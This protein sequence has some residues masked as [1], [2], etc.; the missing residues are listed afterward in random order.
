MI[1]SK[2][3]FRISLFGGGTDFPK[4]YEKYNGKVIGF[5]F[6]R[7]N[8]ILFRSKF[9][10]NNNKF[11]INYSK[12]EKVNNI[13]NIKHPSVRE[14]LKYLKFKDPFELHYNGELPARSGLG[15]S[16]AFTVGLLKILQTIKKKN[17]SALEI[18]KKAIDIEQNKIK[19]IVGSQDQFYASLGGFKKISF[20]KENIRCKNVNIS[21]LNKKKLEDSM[22]LV[23]TGRVR[24]AEKIE[25]QKLQ[26]FEK[27]LKALDELKDYVDICEDILLKE[28]LNIKELGKLMHESWLLKSSLHKNVSNS[29]INQMYKKAKKNGCSGGKILGAGGGGF[30][31]LLMEKNQ[32]KKI[33]RIFNKYYCIDIKINAK[34]S[35]IISKTTDYI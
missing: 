29:L 17:F 19:E 34:G 21:N 31:L 9:Q 2:T 7:Y 35:E 28:N 10:N 16:S 33:R 12:N 14:T 1:I 18:A 26:M 27:N 32:K 23:F 24:N 11:N 4:Y 6:D 25:K 3:P 13:N 20:T 30:L 5:T 15:T 22:M 8:Y